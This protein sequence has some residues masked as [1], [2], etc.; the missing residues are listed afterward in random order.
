MKREIR[1]KIE[2]K[3]KERR[4]KLENKRKK[5]PQAMKKQAMKA[6]KETGNEGLETAEGVE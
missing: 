3:G 1:R 4:A 5:V 2:Y 6:K